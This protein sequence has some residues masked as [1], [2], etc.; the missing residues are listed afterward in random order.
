MSYLSFPSSG[1]ISPLS[2]GSEPVWD[3]ALFDPVVVAPV[4][5]TCFVLIVVFATIAY[6]K[7]SSRRMQMEN[8]SC[9]ESP[10]SPGQRKAE[11]MSMNTL[12]M[13]NMSGHAIVCVA[14]DEADIILTPET[15]AACYDGM[16][17]LFS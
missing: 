16:L 7:A 15:E 6:F 14:N 2:S 17:E 12:R 10:D 1:T 11:S 3:V 9:I 8:H 4:V 13:K 5:C